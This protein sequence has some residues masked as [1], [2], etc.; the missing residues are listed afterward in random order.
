MEE[1]QV[2]VDGVRLALSD[3]FFLVAT[4]NPHDYEGTFP[5]PEV[6][7]DRFLFKLTTGH[8]RA[9][10]EAQILQLSMEGMLPPNFETLR[11][12]EPNLEAIT[13][14]IRATAIDESV[15][16]YVTE[17]LQET[18]RHRSLSSGSS[19]RGGLA[20]CR[21]ARVAALLEGRTYVIP[22]D[23]KRLVPVTLVHR[24]FLTP[25]AEV[26]RVSRER[27]LEEVVEKVPFP[28]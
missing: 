8:G 14:E 2:T 19:V 3:Q 28:S 20:L 7:L 13:A 22:D 18:R 10:D 6:Q 25:D 5:L 16:R 1:R 11:Q 15:L 9:E 27:I 24:V 26:S 21:A 17:I 4:Q 23:I 12:H